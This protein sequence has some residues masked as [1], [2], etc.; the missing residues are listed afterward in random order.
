MFHIYYSIFNIHNCTLTLN[1]TETNKENIENTIQNIKYFTQPTPSDSVGRL[2][3]PLHSYQPFSRG[4]SLE[5]PQTLMMFYPF[6]SCSAVSPQIQNIRK[7]NIK[8]FSTS[9]VFEQ[10]VDPRKS[11]AGVT[12][13]LHFL[14]HPQEWG[15]IKPA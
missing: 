11:S 5:L 15:K 6:S 12:G 13:K 3:T 7:R 4:K 2:C 14:S 8:I 9:P 10:R 1:N